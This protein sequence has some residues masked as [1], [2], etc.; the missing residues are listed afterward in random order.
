M[1][2]RNYRAVKLTSALGKLVEAIK[3]NKI[4]GS[5]DRCFQLEK[6]QYGYGMTSVYTLIQWHS[7]RESVI[8]CIRKV[9][10]IQSTSVSKHCHC[11]PLYLEGQTIVVPLSQHV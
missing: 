2:K 5:V 9:L 6:N 3:R 4:N 1:Q 10:L 11:V 8:M 7:W